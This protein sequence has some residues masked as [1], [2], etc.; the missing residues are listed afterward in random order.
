MTVVNKNNNNQRSMKEGIFTL[1]TEVLV[2]LHFPVN[3]EK[4]LK[5]NILEFSGPDNFFSAYCAASFRL[6]DHPNQ[7]ATITSN[8]PP[9]STMH[10]KGD[11]CK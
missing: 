2:H 1:F 11:L 5:A 8:L 10:F 3:Y 6:H 9:L 7:K 4:Y